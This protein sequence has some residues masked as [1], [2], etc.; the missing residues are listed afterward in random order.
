MRLDRKEDGW[1]LSKLLRPFESWRILDQAALF[2][3]AKWQE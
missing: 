3:L 2:G 1:T